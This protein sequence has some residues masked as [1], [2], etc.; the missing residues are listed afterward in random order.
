MMMPM[1]EADRPTRAPCSG[2]MNV[3]KSQP[4]DSRPLT[5]NTARRGASRNK[6]ITRASSG[7]TGLGVALGA[8]LRTTARAAKASNGNP[9]RIKNVLP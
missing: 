5:M 6:S 3:N 9:A 8:V 1:V 7:G 4:I 2:T